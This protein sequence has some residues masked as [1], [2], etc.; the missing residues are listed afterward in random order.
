MEPVSERHPGGRPRKLERCP[1]GHAIDSLAAE[2]GLHL[3]Q[4]AKASGIT[5]PALHRICTGRTKSPKLNTIMA[6]AAALGI[7]VDR[8]LAP[9]KRPSRRTA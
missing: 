4:V 8:L 9:T 6:I 7:T 3:D 2:R 1:L 5:F